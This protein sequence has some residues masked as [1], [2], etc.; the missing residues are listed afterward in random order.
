MSDRFGTMALGGRSQQV[1]LGEEIA[2][3]REYSETTAREVDEEIKAILIAAY[4]RAEDTLRTHRNGLKAIAAALL[5]KEEMAGEE[6]S[7]LL[8]NEEAGQNGRVTN[9]T[10]ESKETG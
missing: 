4:D 5:E 10:I 3:R 9:I 7:D 6:V 2:H 1:F 8:E